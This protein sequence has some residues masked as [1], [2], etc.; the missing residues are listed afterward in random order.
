[1][2]ILAASLL[3]SISTAAQPT[4]C[5][6]ILLPFV[7]LD[8]PKI[9]MD[10]FTGDFT[11]IYSVAHSAHVGN[12]NEEFYVEVSPHLTCDASAPRGSVTLY[13]RAKLGDD[14]VHPEAIALRPGL[15][16]QNVT[17]L[18]PTTRLFSSSIFALS[19]D[20]LVSMA[21]KRQAIRVRVYA[22]HRAVDLDLPESSVSE[23]AKAFQE[24]WEKRAEIQASSELPPRIGEQVK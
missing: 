20:D 14:F 9:E 19:V 3:L 8:Q 2:S 13:F 5:A 11:V 4:L 10:D 6:P 12:G 23:W 21:Q 16:N 18:T 1:M 22:N 15:R 7:G 17:V 24:L